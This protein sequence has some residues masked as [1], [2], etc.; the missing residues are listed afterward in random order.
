MNKLQAVKIIDAVLEEDI[1]DPNG[2][3]PAGDH[4]SLACFSANVNGNARLICKA[5]GIL[6]GVE[7]AHWICERVDSK[8]NMQVLLHDGSAIKHGDIA[9]TVHGPVRS[10]LR[11]ERVILNFM[12]RMSAIA[13]A[14]SRYVKAVEGTKARILDT[15]KTTPGIRLMEKWAVHIGGGHNHRFGLYDMVMLK[16]NHIDYCGGITAAITAVHTYFKHAN[17]S[18]PIEV[19]VR[20]LQDVEEVLT[21]G[22]VQRIMFDNFTVDSMKDAVQLVNGK[23]ETEA[24]G[25]ITLQTVR[26]YA[27]TGVDFISVG[28]ITHSAGSLD[29]SLKAY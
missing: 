23:F 24:S 2:I 1:I 18:L 25:G 11:V 28:A 10:I 26:D 16:D 21:C 7:L 12:Q 14:T 27:L 8:L 20:T 3:I 19:E 4:S 9:L 22:G 13:T 6:A 29:L 5:D 17:L 15:R